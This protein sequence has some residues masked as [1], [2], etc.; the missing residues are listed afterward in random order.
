[1]NG[2]QDETGAKVQGFKR[3]KSSIQEFKGSR[4]FKGQVFGEPWNLRTF[5]PSNVELLNL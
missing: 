2:S 1:M 4:W 5:E 3:F